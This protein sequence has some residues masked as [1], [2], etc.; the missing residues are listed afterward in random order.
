MK[1][2]VLGQN[3][4][5]KI[6]STTVYH[7]SDVSVKAA[8]TVTK[9]GQ[10][11]VDAIDSLDELYSFDTIDKMFEKVFAVKNKQQVQSMIRNIVDSLKKYA[12]DLEE[13]GLS[14]NSSYVKKNIIP[15]LN[16]ALTTMDS[17]KPKDFF[18]SIK[19][20]REN[21]SKTNP[22][23]NDDI[24][25]ESP[26]TTVQDVF[27]NV[28]YVNVDLDDNTPAVIKKVPLSVFLYKGLSEK[29][30]AQLKSIGC[31]FIP[32]SGAML[33]SDAKFLIINKNKFHKNS[34]Y[35]ST[36]TIILQA[37]SKNA[38]FG[39]LLAVKD[40]NLNV[41]SFYA[42]LCVT[43]NQVRAFSEVAESARDIKVYIK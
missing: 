40:I 39:S 36:A 16:K 28:K 9:T 32:Y 41:P 13:I 38:K 23:L 35:G 11:K 43:Q 21:F 20:I 26:L 6:R 12:E 34:N 18:A 10:R 30:M 29:S 22:E 5:K 2:I 31:Q 4:K 15:A 24:L 25:D 27:K 1:K 14:K 3:K 42:V 17:V 37:I 8:V 33:Y 7:D 19:K